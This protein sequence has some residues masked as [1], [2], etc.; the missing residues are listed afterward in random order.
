MYLPQGELQPFHHNYSLFMSLSSAFTA[1]LWPAYPLSPMRPVILFPPS[2]TSS[3]IPFIFA[4]NL[5]SRVITSYFFAA[6]SFVL[7]SSL[8]QSFIC[9]KWCD[10]IT[11][12][13]GRKAQLHTWLPVPEL[14]DR[15]SVTTHWQ[16]LEEVIWLVT[17]HHAY[18]YLYSD[19]WM[20][21]LVAKFVLYAIIHS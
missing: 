21:E 5:T 12:N 4:F 20:K 2:P 8:F 7:A 17:D 18:F 14:N 19:F 1:S 13:K 3:V 16:T 6:L 15:G 10:F 11:P 9:I